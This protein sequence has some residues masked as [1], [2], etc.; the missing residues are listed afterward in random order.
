MARAERID[1]NVLLAQDMAK[2]YADP[3]GFVLYAY[4]WNNDAAL[5][6]V[7]LP[8]AYRKRYP[9]CKFGPDQWA[10]EF[11]DGIGAQVAERHFD[12]Q[13]AVEAIREAVASGHGVGKSACTAWLVDWLMS[14]RPFAKGVVTANTSAQ[15]ES[16]T[17]AEIAKWT[18]R[19]ITGHWFEVNTGRGSMKM[20]H[21]QHPEAWQCTAQTSREENA[22]A[23]AGLH[24]ANSTPFYIFDEAS[25]IPEAIYDVAE[26]GL[27]D[28]EPHIYLFG[29]PTR[30]SGAFHRCFNGMR[31]RW[32]CR[33][34][35]SRS[36]AITN[37]EQIN[38]WVEDYGEDSDFVRIRVR[39]VFPRAGSMQFIDSE[40]VGA[41]MVRE[42]E[43]S[44]YDPLILGVDPARFGDDQTVIYFRKGRDGRTHP[45]IK[46]RGADTM[47]TAAKVA[48]IYES[49]RPDGIFVDGGGVGGGVVDRLRQLRVPCI[50]VQFGSSPDRSIPGQELIAYANKGAEMWGNM[51]DW[52]KGGAIPDDHELRTELESREYGYVLIKGRDSIQLESKRDMKERGLASPDIADAL[53]LTFAYPVQPN[54][55]AGRY[56]HHHARQAHAETEY[57]I[58]ATLDSRMA[59]GRVQSEYNPLE[60]D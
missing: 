17:W 42:A 37:K 16:K 18:K 28:G 56:G 43:A 5:Q 34:I 39:G 49:M 31:H 32:N 59:A 15:L 22:E 58:Y 60:V 35:D 13:H 33:Q 12:G 3:L 29:N 20:Y 36:V 19:C 4:D 23:F 54:A 55:N 45:P 41:A 6:I 14:T 48:E 26:G 9:H 38:Q 44:L 8:E 11:L 10:C 46:L 1:P 53:A 47:T 57:D 40:L 50:E 2:F 51:R 25:A 24:A 21:K 52:L 30:N 27:T 7:E